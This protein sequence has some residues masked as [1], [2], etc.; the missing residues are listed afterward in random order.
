MP[1]ADNEFWATTVGVVSA[2]VAVVAG[3]TNGGYKAATG[4]G[5]FNNGFESARKAVTQ[6][7]Q[8]FGNEHGATITRAVITATV[9]LVFATAR[10]LAKK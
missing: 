4:T 6:G 3:L 10:D 5:S 8:Q 9:G 7:A 1:V 2:P